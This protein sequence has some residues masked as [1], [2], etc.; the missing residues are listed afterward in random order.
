MGV[1]CWALKDYDNDGRTTT[2]GT[3]ITTTMGDRWTITAT[4]TVYAERLSNR[5]RRNRRPKAQA[6][7]TITGDGYQ[8]LRQERG[9]HLFS[10]LI[11]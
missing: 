1:G 11:S 8:T 7:W 6:R 3:T 10:F 9:F 4:I 5:P 2:I